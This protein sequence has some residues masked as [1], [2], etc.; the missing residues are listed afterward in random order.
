VALVIV[1]P[2][3][4]HHQVPVGPLF[5]VLDVE[6]SGLDPRRHRII[7]VAVVVTDAGGDIVDEWSSLVHPRFG[8]AG[9]SHVHGLRRADLRD[10]PR[11]A[12]IAPALVDRLEGTVVVA[13]NAD[14]DWAFMLREFQ[15]A[16]V[17]APL[18]GRLCTLRLSRSLD[19]ERLLR[20][21]LSDLCDR[22]G[23]EVTQPHDAAADARATARALPA[24]LAAAGLAG[25][26]DIAGRLQFGAP[27]RHRR[28]TWRRRRQRRS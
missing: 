1:E 14:F 21:R 4:G 22:L 19:P 24:L 6:T 16:K 9:P 7:Q 23:I 10:A 2:V 18:I 5:S 26:D 28:R 20:H 11:F 27:P 25:A 3:A 17:P 12:A 8:R 13:H 15:R